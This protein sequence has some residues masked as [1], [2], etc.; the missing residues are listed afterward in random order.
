[1]Q[2]A[3]NVRGSWI[4]GLS[5]IAAALTPVSALADAALY[6]AHCSKCHARA[7]TLA[8]KLKG[9]SEEEKASRLHA[10]LTT[11]HAEDAETRANIVAYLVDLSKK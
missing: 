9:Q 11:H 10:F 5:L 8:V 3:L 6:K 4:A 1:M 2:K 7:G